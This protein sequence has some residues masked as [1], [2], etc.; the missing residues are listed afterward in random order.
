MKLQ[1]RHI[2]VSSLKYNFSITI[3]VFQCVFSKGFPFLAIS[4]LLSELF[5]VVRLLYSL[6]FMI[7]WSY[8]V[9]GLNEN[10]FSTATEGGVTA[11]LV[12]NFALENE[13]INLIQVTLD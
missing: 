5:L 12:E 3:Q 13:A 2:S 4:L 6:D 10:V 9:C 8:K 1:W 11:N 7:M